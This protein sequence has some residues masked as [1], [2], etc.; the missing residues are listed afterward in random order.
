[1]EDQGEFLHPEQRYKMTNCP[2]V[3]GTKEV[4]S[5][6]KC[7]FKNRENTEQM[8]RTGLLRE[9]LLSRVE[10]FAEVLRLESN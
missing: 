3:S 8:G 1:M 4:L 10:R 2:E 6:D 9:Q 7:Q 5:T